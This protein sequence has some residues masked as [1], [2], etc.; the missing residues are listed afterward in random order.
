[1]VEGVVMVVVPVVF[2]EGA[3]QRMV[4]VIAIYMVY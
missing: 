4:V 1:M 3:I 2:V